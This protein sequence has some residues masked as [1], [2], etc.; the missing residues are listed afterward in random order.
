MLRAKQLPMVKTVFPGRRRKD[1]ETW[2]Q[3]SPLSSSA[4]SRQRARLL[5]PLRR[6]A[7]V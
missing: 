4:T 7:S 3:S 5:P 1:G 6:L 2:G